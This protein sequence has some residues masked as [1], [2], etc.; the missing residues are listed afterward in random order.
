[1]KKATAILII[2]AIC[3]LANTASASYNTGIVAGS[4]QFIRN[5][6]IAD[7]GAVIDD[8][9]ANNSTGVFMSFGNNG[10]NSGFNIGEK[11]GIDLD[12]YDI[13]EPDID[14]DNEGS[15]PTIPEPI[16]LILMGFGLA[17]GA[18]LRK[19]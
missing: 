18:L 3:F 7:N 11:Y 15:I 5:Y 17:G 8:Q 9:A 2:I 12:E 13:I 16:T 19:K 10:G 14:P 4:M 6:E 1:M